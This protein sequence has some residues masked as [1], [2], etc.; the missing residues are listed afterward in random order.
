MSKKYQN[1][2]DI[3]DYKNIVFID[4]FTEFLDLDFKAEDIEVYFE[5]IEPYSGC[6][7]QCKKSKEN[8]NTEIISKW[9]D[10]YL[11]DGNEHLDL[12][13]LFDES[14]E[15]N[16][17]GTCYAMYLSKVNSVDFIDKFKNKITEWGSAESEG[18]FKLDFLSW[19]E[20]DMFSACDA[21]E[22]I[23]SFYDSIVG[24][25]PN[26]DLQ[27]IFDGVDVDENKN[28]ISWLSFTQLEVAEFRVGYKLKNS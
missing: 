25:V 6:Y 2:N 7:W 27:K 9:S 10:D 8:K 14:N 1:L 3:I 28:K 26:E 4:D 5:C 24:D 18:P 20:Y 16:E 13:N 11:L 12:K 17:F 15:I 21:D 22:H 19:L 23:G